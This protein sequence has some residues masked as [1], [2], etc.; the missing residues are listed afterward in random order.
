MPIIS[1][2]IPTYNREKYI[3]KAL[4]SVFLQSF[5][6]FEI[7]VVDDG[8]TDGTK[9]LLEPLIKGGKVKYLYQQ[10]LRV[11]KARNNGIKNSSGKYYY[12]SS[13]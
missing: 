10:N 9:N 8:S 6:D 3:Q 11:S 5:Q 1:V 13:W 12:S 4:D 2:I 7:I